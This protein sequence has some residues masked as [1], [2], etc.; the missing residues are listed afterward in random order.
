MTTMTAAFQ[1]FWKYIF[2]FKGR[3]TRKD[4]FLNVLWQAVWLGMIALLLAL[5][6][7]NL[8]VH[9]SASVDN[10]GLTAVGVLFFVSVLAIAVPSLSLMVR[11]FNDIGLNYW[12][13]R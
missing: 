9:L 8:L 6:S 13:G 5:F 11:R 7:N 10:T 3:T 12:A 4:Y 2:D 1:G